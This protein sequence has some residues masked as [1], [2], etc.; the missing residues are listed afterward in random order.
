MCDY[1]TTEF[2]PRFSNAFDFKQFFNG[3]PGIIGWTIINLSFA[4]LQY[5]TFEY[6]TLPMIV[7]NILQLFYVVDFFWNED[8][9]LRTID[10][11][12]E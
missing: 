8:W 7:V 10:I 9:Y 4:G 2:N 6:I 1:Q 11:A 3:R 12:H 5:R